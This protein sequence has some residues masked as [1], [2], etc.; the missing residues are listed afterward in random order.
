MTMLLYPT[1]HPVNRAK[2]VRKGLETERSLRISRIPCL[3]VRLSQSTA[4]AI[5]FTVLI[6]DIQVHVNTEL[7]TMT[8]AD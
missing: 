3:V 1:F 8:S 4:E 5:I 6:L 7:N 2:I